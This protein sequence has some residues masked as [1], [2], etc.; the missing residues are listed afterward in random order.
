M[1]VDDPTPSTTSKRPPVPAPRTVRKQD[2]LEPVKV[3]DAAMKKWAHEMLS[4]HPGCRASEFKEWR[5][6]YAIQFK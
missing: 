1:E 4:G 2:L 3:Y 6:S 5:N